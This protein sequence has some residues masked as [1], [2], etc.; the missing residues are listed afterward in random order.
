MAK[1]TE[2]EILKE[3]IRDYEEK[4]EYNEKVILEKITEKSIYLNQVKEEVDAYRRA[5][6]TIDDH[7]KLI[8]KILSMRD[9]LLDIAQEKFPSLYKEFARDVYDDPMEIL[10]FINAFVKEITGD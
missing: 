6:K 1:K 2:I 7:N 5:K 4:F 9:N 8:D 10:R 3:I